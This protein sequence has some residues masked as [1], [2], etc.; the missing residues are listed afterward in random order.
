MLGQSQV[1]GIRPGLAIGN[2]PGVCREL[3]ERI[4]GL[5]R[6]RWKLAEGIRSLPGV[7]RELAERDQELTRMASGSSL[8]EDQKTHWKIVWGSRKACRELERSNETCW[9]C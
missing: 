4:R 6:V 9:S 7:H 2:S 8:E 1:R 3:A 5:L